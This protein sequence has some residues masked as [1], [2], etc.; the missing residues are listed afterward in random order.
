M[1]RFLILLILFLLNFIFLLFEI[2]LNH[3][4]SLLLGSTVTAST[5]VLSVFMGGLG[6]GALFNGFLVKNLKKYLTI[7]TI[8]IGILGFGVNYILEF[9]PNLYELNLPQFIIVTIVSLLILLLT[10]PMGGVLPIVANLLIEDSKNI[11]SSV[12]NLYIFETLASVFGGLL[13]GFVFLRYIGVENTILLGSAISIISFFISFKVRDTDYLAKQDPVKSENRSE[14]DRYTLLKMTAFS[15]MVIFSYQIFILRALKVYLTNTTYTFTIVSASVIIGLTLGSFIFSVT[16]K[17]GFKNLPKIIFIEAI[18]LSISL[19]V[20]INIPKWILIPLHNNLS[21]PILRI[22]LPAILTSLLI[23]VPIS[24]VSGYIFPAI[25]STYIRDDFVKES[26]IVVFFNSIGIVLGTI[27]SGFFILP[28]L[29]VY[30][31]LI[32]LILT[33][34]LG[35]IY[36]DKKI[37]S[38]VYPPAIFMVILITPLFIWEKKILPPSFSIVDREVLYYSET[39]EGTVSIGKEKS[40]KIISFINNSQVMGISYDAVKTVKML[41]YLP[42]LAGLDPKDVLIVGFGIGGTTSTINNL[43]TVENIDCVELVPDVKSSAN[44][45]MEY[46]NGVEKSEKLNIIGGDGRQF[47]LK[48]D[49][50]YDIISSD[51]THPVLGSGPLY[52]KEYFSL[53]KSKL[54]PNGFVTQYLPLHKLSVKDFNSILLTF[55]NVFPNMTLWLG[56]SH[57]ILMGSKSKLEIDYNDFYKRAKMIKDR[58][59]YSDPMHLASV[60]ICNGETI[61]K[62]GGGEVIFDDKNILNFFNPEAFNFDNW[63]KNITTIKKLYTDPGEVFRN[64]NDRN[65]VRNYKKSRELLIDAFIEKN[66][67]N[68]KA[69]LQ[70]MKKAANINRE[71]QEIPFLIRSEQ[72]VR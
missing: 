52:T 36:F 55:A 39:K 41:G 45:Y 1:N 32:L 24:I 17:I 20:L 66:R 4:L 30:K 65:R 46:N 67:G 7:L 63:E 44:Y 8:S 28:L 40:G 34:V 37:N 53:C 25:L 72:M 38:R 35:Y 22:G 5:I 13:T 16:R 3:K 33:I 11:K 61:K 68:R 12:G 31:S 62:N 10:F 15:G 18:I 49:K 21:E 70:L 71:D 59:F 9:I 43:K 69:Y 19:I 47:M 56:Q 64:L 48:T 60:Y 54:K 14:K 26:G 2:S 57:A 58:W 23:M 27:I 6:I 51:P 29:G 50:R 42:Y